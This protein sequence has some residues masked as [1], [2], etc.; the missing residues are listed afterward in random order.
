MVTTPL[1]FVATANTVRHAGAVP[2][3]VDVDPVTGLIEPD[4]VLELLERDCETRD[5]GSLWHSATGTRAER[6]MLR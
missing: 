6:R 1:T 5:D 4:A 2:L 3:F